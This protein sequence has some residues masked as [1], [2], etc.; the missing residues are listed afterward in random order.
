MKSLN[1]LNI[2]N[3]PEKVNVG[4]T[5]NA[6]PLVKITGYDTKIGEIE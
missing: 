6:T 2:I 3:E 1:T 4:Q 5:I